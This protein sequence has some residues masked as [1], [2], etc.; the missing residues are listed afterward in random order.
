MCELHT[1]AACVCECGD[2]A[3]HGL[4]R[5]PAL[6]LGSRQEDILGI[7]SEVELQVDVEVHGAACLRF[8]AY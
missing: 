3:Y 6:R 8:N 4:H 5:L 7:S 2:R 1:A